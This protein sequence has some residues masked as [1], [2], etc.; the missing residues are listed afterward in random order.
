MRYSRY[1]SNANLDRKRILRPIG[2]YPY[3]YNKNLTPIFLLPLHMN[4]H[5]VYQLEVVCS[6]LENF[7]YTSLNVFVY[8]LLIKIMISQER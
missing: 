3:Q 1:F 8:V 2:S 6:P 7:Q 4:Q 5:N